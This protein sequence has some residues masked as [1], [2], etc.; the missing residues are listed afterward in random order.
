[1]DEWI[2]KLWYV[3]TM[4]YYLALKKEG[5]PTICNKDESEINE[6]NTNSSWYYTYVESKIQ[7]EKGKYVR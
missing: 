6:T 5:D 1:M 7:K 4:E 2:K 3:C